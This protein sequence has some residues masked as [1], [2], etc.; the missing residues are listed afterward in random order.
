MRWAEVRHR[1]LSVSARIGF[2]LE[3]ERPLRITRNKYLSPMSSLK[4]SVRAKPGAKR[5]HVG[6]AVGDALAVA[7][8]APAVDGKANDAVIEALADAF[9]VKKREVSVLHGHTGRDK[10]MQIEG[11]SAH[12]TARLNQLKAE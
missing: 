3:A 8:T 11:D 1:V 5:T 7:V 6:G 4:I 2:R 10:V 12:L 9:G